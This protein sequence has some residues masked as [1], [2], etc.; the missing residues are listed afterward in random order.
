LN[1]DIIFEPTL[2]RAVWRY[3]WLV[4]LVTVLATAAAYYYADS[5]AIEEW[6]AEASVVAEDPL[7]DIIFESTPTR[8]ADYLADQV[9]L[10]RSG[11]LAQEAAQIAR[12]KNPVF[13]YSGDA[14][15]ER[16][17]LFESGARITVRVIAET[18]AAA[19]DG[20]N[21]LTEAYQA[22][23]QRDALA[24][25]T[26]AIDVLGLVI[27]DLER[28]LV[29]IGTEIQAL[30]E[31]AD[32]DLADL[33]AQYAAA[34]PRLVTLFER[35][36]TAEGEARLALLDQIDYVST[37]LAVLEQVLRIEGT[38]PEITP[39]LDR[40]RRTIIRI[41]ELSEQ[42]DRY[43]VD[44]QLLGAGVGSSTRATFASLVATDVLRL[45]A[46]GAFLGL[47][48]GSGVAYMLALRRRS[49]SDRAQPELILA[50]PLIAEVPNFRH[51]GIRTALP[52]RSHPR[53][54]AA[55]SF[56]FAAAALDL[57]RAAPMGSIITEGKLVV[58]TSAN[59][60]DGKTVIAANTALAAAREGKRVLL[61]DAD[62]GS[63][64][65]TAMLTEQRVD[66]GITEVV[67]S[68][69]A[70]SEAVLPIEGT[71]TAGLH[72]LGR[73]W[74]TTSAPEF[75]RNPATR[76][77]LDQIQEFYDLI[78]LDAPPLLTVAY[79][80]TIAGMVDKV[81][82][83]TRHNSPAAALEELQDRLDLIGTPTVGY[84]YN[85]APLRLD[86]SRN[87]G[88]MRDVLGT[89]QALGSETSDA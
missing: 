84:V 62:F 68:G 66:S 61:I 37:Q 31:V 57:S 82:V 35:L 56:R 45:V 60:A 54:A 13:P 44:A 87:E 86:I 32:P 17:R 83:V 29:D 5:T 24:F 88:S 36:E 72:L 7:S 65:A 49:I 27:A 26:D 30:Q 14:L 11:D 64:E 12:E 71:G 18:E 80:S 70:I 2:L 20:A 50:A 6:S 74:Q 34:L 33:N 76:E 48:T 19:V 16:T 55:E 23:V 69:T 81:L 77:F 9:E 28:E 53:S 46:A 10:M 73:G 4:L 43:R 78:L 47:L 89:R 1:D 51:E 3:R 38:S 25:F 21:S 79:A 59:V 85:Q 8:R 58:V 41:D 42:R 22:I 39:L 63:Q 15:L 67:E 40:Q 52:V 75:F